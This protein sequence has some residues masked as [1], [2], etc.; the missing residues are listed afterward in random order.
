[1]VIKMIITEKLRRISSK[2][3]GFTALNAVC[4][5]V[6]GVLNG[7]LGSGGG[8]ILIFGMNLLLPELDTK[9]KFVTAV[10]S[11][12]PMSVISA[13]FYCKS[14]GIDMTSAT[15]YLSAALFGGVFGAWLMTVISPGVLKNIFAALMIWA[16][17]RAFF[18]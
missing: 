5:T 16:G 13:Y 6:A 15:P 18:R 12:I 9:D 14:G 3:W 4:G 2:K 8:I 17:F 10:A 7:F 11:I 1:M